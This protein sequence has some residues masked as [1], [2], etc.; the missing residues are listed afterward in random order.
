MVASG[1]SAPARHRLAGDWLR[2]VAREA[3]SLLFLYL[4]S[5]IVASTGLVVV[6]LVSGGFALPVMVAYVPL[7]WVLCTPGGLVSVTAT[8][9]LADGIRSTPVKKVGAA[10]GLTCGLIAW[11]SVQSL[12]AW[13]VRGPYDYEPSQGAVLILVVLPAVLV[14]AM[15][16]ALVSRRQVSASRGTSRDA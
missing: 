2:V 10:L 11:L 13:R 1:D 16:A 3:T 6:G 14:G 7:F 9:A 8:M 15:F 12:V 5:L 4:C